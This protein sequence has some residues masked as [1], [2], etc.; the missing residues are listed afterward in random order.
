M[1]SGPTGHRNIILYKIVQISR[2]GRSI[3]SMETPNMEY[4]D[5]LSAGDTAF[6]LKL[7]GILQAELPQEIAEYRQKMQQHDMN[8]ATG[9][10]HKL[11]HKIS[12]LGMEKSYYIAEQFEINLKSGATKLQDE[13]E[14]I[15]GTMQQFVTG[16]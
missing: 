8:G 2:H 6:R 1:G 16:L 11:K 5:N 7:I 4:I 13:F 15:L 12:L 14:E 3:I 10:V 9:S